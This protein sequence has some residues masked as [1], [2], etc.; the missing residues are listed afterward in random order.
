MLSFHNK[1]K[2]PKRNASE[3]CNSLL[4]RNQLLDVLSRSLLIE[5]QRNDLF[6][7]QKCSRHIPDSWIILLL[8]RIRST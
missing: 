8:K 4:L 5:M 6:S 3:M 1:Q 7:I 2:A